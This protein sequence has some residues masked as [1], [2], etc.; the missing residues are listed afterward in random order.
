[1]IPLLSLLGT[2]GRT[3][4]ASN[5]IGKLVGEAATEE[6]EKIPKEGAVEGAKAMQRCIRE[7]FSQRFPGSKHYSPSKVTRAFNY[8][9][10]NV[11]GVTRAYQ[12][13][14]IYPKN[15]AWLCIPVN[16][17]AK[18]RSPSDFSN[19]FKPKDHNILA[20]NENGK[21]VVYYALSKHVHQQQDSTIMPSDEKL[22]D[23]ALAAMGKKFD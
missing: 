9:Y 20:A 10:V 19:L 13:I 1:M 3:T 5:M 11:P 12:S 8:V 14:D 7:H 4:A 6:L 15:A 21:L 17:A 22:S 16:S 18:G 2:I 23:V